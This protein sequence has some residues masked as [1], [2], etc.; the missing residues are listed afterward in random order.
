MLTSISEAQ[1]LTLLEAGA[2]G[3]PSVATQVG[4]CEQILY[5]N[6]DE[7]PPLG[8]GGI[9]TPLVNP[10]ATA[11]AIVQLLSDPVFYQNCSHAIR[12]RI[13]TYYRYEQQQEAYRKLY[14]KYIGM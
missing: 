1:P 5:G 10:E 6:P 3:I 11:Q 14:T 9:L 7:D 2:V 12:Q 13:Q 8:Q 4:A